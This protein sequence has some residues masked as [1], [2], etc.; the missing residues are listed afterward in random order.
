MP[1]TTGSRGEQVGGG[2]G[3]SAWV[4]MAKHDLG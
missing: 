4:G 1:R 2:E 3:G